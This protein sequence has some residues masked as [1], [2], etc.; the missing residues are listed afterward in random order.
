MNGEL[1]PALSGHKLDNISPRDGK[2]FSTIPDSHAEDVEL[3]VDAA[4]NA[5]PKWKTTSSEDRC[6]ILTRIADLIA[7]HHAEL[8]HAESLDNGKPLS[9]AGHV[10]IPRAESNMRFFASGAQ[11][12]ASESHVMENGVVNYTYRKPLGVVGCISPWNLPLYLFT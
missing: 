12:F 11:H 5:F 10:D 8:S 4:Q 2:V 1:T 6:K 3:A 7:T 9:L